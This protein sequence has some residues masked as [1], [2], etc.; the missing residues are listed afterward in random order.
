MPAGGEIASPLTS[1]PM[2]IV[3][4]L[5]RRALPARTRRLLRE[6]AR[7]LPMRA[8]DFVPDAAERLRGAKMPPLPPPP[9]RR[10]VGRSSSRREYVA[11]G[12][13]AA[14]EIV[15]AARDSAPGHGQAAWLDFGCG[16]GRVARHMPHFA[17]AQPT[18][19][20]IDV[21]AVAW[22][23]R[24][25]EGRF[26][27]S[28]RFPPLPF[29]T[30]SFD[31]IYAV[32]VVSHFDEEAQGAW[33]GELARVLRNGGLFVASTH[34]EGLRYSRPDLTYEQHVA[35]NN[36][37]LEPPGCI[38]QAQLTDRRWTSAGTRGRGQGADH[39]IAMTSSLTDLN[40][41]QIL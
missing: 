41:F 6:V 32:S 24:H 3:R 14:A 27:V 37:F 28:D 23:A 13:R 33:L 19:V 8:V 38:G 21:V 18:G 5:A 34:G 31:V 36:G 11:V 35:L 9:L 39:S 26:L 20:D 12:K 22:A 1:A 2:G 15:R 30:E 10:S 40:A 4:D 17:G 16:S 7:E 25:L 29:A